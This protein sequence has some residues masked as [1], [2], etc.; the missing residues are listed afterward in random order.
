MDNNKIHHRDIECG[1]TDWTDLAQDTEE[2]RA[3][4]STA[5]NLRGFFKFVES[6]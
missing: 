2:G 5:M 3:P 6:S 1:G 4:V